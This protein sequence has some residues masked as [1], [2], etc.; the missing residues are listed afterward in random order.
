MKYL[1]MNV[2][3]YTIN[4]SLESLYFF[5]EILYFIYAPKSSCI[6]GNLDNSYYENIRNI[7]YV[8][9]N[10]TISTSDTMI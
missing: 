3:Q 8:I 2:K 10:V 6:V 9:D 7:V 1:P 4:Q 5:V